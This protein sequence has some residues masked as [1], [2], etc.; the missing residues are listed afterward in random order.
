MPS[1]S[2][3]NAIYCMYSAIFFREI[4]FFPLKKKTTFDKTRIRKMS[5]YGAWDD[6][7]GPYPIGPAAERAALEKRAT[8]QERDIEYYKQRIQELEKQL[9]Q[10]DGGSFCY[11]CNKPVCA[12]CRLSSPMSMGSRYC[13]REC[14]NNLVDSYSSKK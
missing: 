8:R 14:F 5:G 7:W 9:S 1:L 2:N 12:S 6:D 4:V 10:R 3:Q 11:M 13:C